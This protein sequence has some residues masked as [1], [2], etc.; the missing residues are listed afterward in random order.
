M[1]QRFPS[2][3]VLVVD[4]APVDDEAARVA[5]R[6]GVDYLVAPIPGLSHARNAAVRAAPGEIIAW[7]DDD[8]IADEHWLGEI[9]RGLRTHPGADILCGAVVPA[10]LET[11]AQLWF[12]QF[13]G[14]VKGRGFTPAVFSPA[15]RATHHPLFPLPPFG[16]G[17]NMVTRPGVVERAGGFDPALGAGSAA[18]GGEDTLLFMEVLR[19][20]GTIAYEPSIL[21]RHFHRRELA[22]LRDQLVGYGTGLTAAYTALVRRHPLAAFGLA[23]LAARAAREVLGSGGARTATIEADFPAELLRA[24]RRAMKRGPA[25]YLC[26]RRAVAG[27]PS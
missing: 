25:A 11:L 3:R 13:G 7:I 4:N 15:T 23:G 18:S 10:E 6:T 26:G 2:F 27:D 16:A 19:A 1:A 21:A 20:G 8:E 9:A 17:A 24:N 12:E 5:R 14:L 22:G